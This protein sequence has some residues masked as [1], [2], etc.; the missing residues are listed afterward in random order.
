MSSSRVIKSGRCG[1]RPAANFCFT[2]FQKDPSEVFHLRSD[3]FMPFFADSASEPPEEDAGA[4]FAEAL[5]SAKV[6]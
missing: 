1:E 3:G 5:I 2:D 4:T 6:R